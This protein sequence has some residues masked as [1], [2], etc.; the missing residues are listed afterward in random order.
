L[1]AIALGVGAL[2]SVGP[3]LLIWFGAEEVIAGR[4][5]VGTLMAFYA[6]LGLLYTPVQRLTELNLILANS[7]AAMD[8]IFEVFDAQSEVK[9]RVGARDLGRVQGEIAFEDVSFNYDNGVTV[10]DR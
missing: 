3:I 7:L 2:T 6:Y 9:E 8:R 4:L 10:L 1:Q 5:T